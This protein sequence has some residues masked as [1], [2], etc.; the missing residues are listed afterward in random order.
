MTEPAIFELNRGALLSPAAAGKTIVHR[1]T[2]DVGFPLVFG[3]VCGLLSLGLL[4]AAVVTAF[5][6]PAAILVVFELAIAAGLGWLAIGLVP[7][8]LAARRFNRRRHEV[9]FTLKHVELRDVDGVERVALA[10]AATHPFLK[11]LVIDCRVHALVRVRAAC[12]RLAPRDPVRLILETLV[13]DVLDVEPSFD[14]PDPP[15]PRPLHV[16]LV[17][18]EVR[19][20]YDPADLAQLR[21]EGLTIYRVDTAWDPESRIHEPRLIPAAVRRL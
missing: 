16:I 4:A 19:P 11:S 3:A 12:K 7:D 6:V 21:A 13:L 2:R 14:G 18:G 10:D 20:V 5:A 9:R 8:A 15:P 1:P 17:D